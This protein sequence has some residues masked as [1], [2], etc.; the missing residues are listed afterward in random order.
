MGEALIYGTIG[1]T[2]TEWQEGPGNGGYDG[3]GF[4]YG[5]GVDYLVSPQFFIGAEYLVRDVESDWT[6]GTFD[7]DLDT[8]T[9]RAGMKF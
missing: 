2:L 4:L 1:A 5:V 7:A 9:L 6:G 8:L 3:N